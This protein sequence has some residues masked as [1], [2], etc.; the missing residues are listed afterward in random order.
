MSKCNYQVLKNEEGFLRLPELDHPSI[1]RYV[2]F[3][4][5]ENFGYL[6]LQLC[7]FTLEEYIEINYESLL[8]NKLVRLVKLVKLVLKSLKVLHCEN[9]QILH[10]DIKPQNV[11]IGKTT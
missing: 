5:D 1:V 10:R 7:E 11:L 4:E 3:A 9:P 2:D 8:T 6:A